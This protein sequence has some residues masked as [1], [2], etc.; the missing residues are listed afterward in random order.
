M[1]IE[2]ICSICLETLENDFVCMNDCYHQFHNECIKNWII[3]NQNHQ[4]FCPLCPLCRN[5]ISNV[6][7][8]HVNVDIPDMPNIPVIEH[9]ELDRCD[10]ICFGYTTLTFLITLLFIFFYW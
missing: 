2:K 9:E 3:Y 1:E 10:R 5:I 6:T 8:R 7:I 4:I